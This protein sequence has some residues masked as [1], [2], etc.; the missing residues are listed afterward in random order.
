MASSGVWI[1]V[2]DSDGTP[3][4]RHAL[5]TSTINTFYSEE[6]MTRNFDSVS[7]YMYQVID[8]YIGVYN[9]TDETLRSIYYNLRNACEYLIGEGQM[10]NYTNITVKQH[11]LL[12][13]RVVAYIDCGLP[14]AVNNVELFITAQAYKLDAVTIQSMQEE[15]AK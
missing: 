3:Q 12:L 4:S 13:D 8:T 2:E 1:C 14:F 10:I 5:T 7:K 15:E 6:M 9:V 11:D